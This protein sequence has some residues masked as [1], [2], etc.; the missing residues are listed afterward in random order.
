[1]M[2]RLWRRRTRSISYTNGPAFPLLAN[3]NDL[4]GVDPVDRTK[5]DGRLQQSLM[6]RISTSS[7]R[8]AL[9]SATSRTP[10]SLLLTFGPYDK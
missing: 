6:Q 10:F 2:S 9:S 5:D 3:G 8:H 1:M 7:R 4:D